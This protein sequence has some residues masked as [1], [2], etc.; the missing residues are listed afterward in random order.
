MGCAIRLVFIGLAAL[1]AAHSAQASDWAFVTANGDGSLTVYVDRSSPRQQ[2]QW[3]KAWARREYR[4]GGTSPIASKPFKSALDLTY[5]DCMSHRTAI[6][7]VRYYR[8][9]GA[10]G[11]VVD[12][13]SNEDFSLN[14]TDP[15][16]D[17]MG[18]SILNFVCGL[19]LQK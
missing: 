5:Y 7:S 6:K 2:A 11:G 12:S 9:P 18:E 14:F 8:E 3:V 4:A 15:P 13:F 16:P 1:L 10:E 19:P 17:S